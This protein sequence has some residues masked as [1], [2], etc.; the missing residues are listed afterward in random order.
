M[1]RKIKIL[2]ETERRIEINRPLNADQT[3]CDGCGDYTPMLTLEMAAA[4]ARLGSGAIRHWV[5][6]AAFH[7][8]QSRA[9][10]LRI[11]ERSFLEH[12]KQINFLPKH[13]DP[14]RQSA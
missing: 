4:M 6:T 10:L 2:I 5:T 13:S 12:L 14:S 9:G 11:C 1:R 3:W 8:Q 7:Y